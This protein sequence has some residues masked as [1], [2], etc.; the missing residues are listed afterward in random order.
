MKI[1]VTHATAFNFQD[2]LYKPLRNSALNAQHEFILP[3]E[4]GREVITKE[5][6]KTCDLILAEVSYPSTGQGIELGWADI[7]EIPIICLYKE[8]ATPSLSLSH[9]S[10]KMLMYTSVENMLS[11]IEGVLQQYG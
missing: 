10:K 7:F 2:E 9:V 6:I 11:D 3:Q 5:L 1:I 8:G 4:N